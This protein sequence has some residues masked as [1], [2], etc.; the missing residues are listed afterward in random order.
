MR[1]Y[2]TI[3]QVARRLRISIST[4]KR[5]LNEP[6][7][8]IAD[9][10]NHIGWRLFAEEDVT[11]LKVYK[12]SIKRNGK[13]FNGATLLPAPVDPTLPFPQARVG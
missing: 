12:S 1:Q 7:V 4:L 9:R 10:R 3:G 13:R 11:V 8:V 6:E 5:W 2:L